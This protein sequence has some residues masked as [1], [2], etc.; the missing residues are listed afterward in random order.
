MRSL[1]SKFFF[2]GAAIAMAVPQ[3]KRSRKYLH[4]R[5]LHFAPKNKSPKTHSVVGF[6]RPDCGT[7]AHI[8]NCPPT[9][10]TT[11]SL[12]QA[13]Q[14]FTP[15][16]GAI[17]QGQRS[18]VRFRDLPA[19]RQAYARSARFRREKWNE[20]ICRIHDARARCLARILRCNQTHPRQP[21]V[22][23]PPV[24]SEASAALCR[25]LISSC[26][27]CAASA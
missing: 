10:A 17:H 2:T 27:S 23:V 5:H 16:S 7:C 18:T 9:S 3:L 8:D 6:H 13:Q 1:D 26:S 20:Q 24:S 19:Q 25:M 12:R 11:R 21:V 15:G 22:T 14:R 4:C